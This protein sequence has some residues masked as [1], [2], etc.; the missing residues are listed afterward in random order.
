M[1]YIKLFENFNIINTLFFKNG[2]S[3]SD[4]NDIKELAP[5]YFDKFIIKNNMIKIY[6]N[7]TLL[8]S[9]INNFEKTYF[10][11]YIGE[12]WS[13][14]DNTSAIWGDRGD[15]MDNERVE[16][17]CTGYLKIEDIDWEMMKYTFNEYPPHFCEEYEI[18]GINNGQTIKIDKCTLI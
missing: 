14:S 17:Q 8:K 15:G 9:E 16:Y 5:D 12:Y 13:L 3:Y 4:V 7:I 18:R 1:K 11:G 6:R 10:D 2:F